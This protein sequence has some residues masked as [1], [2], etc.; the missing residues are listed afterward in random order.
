[1][2]SAELQFN[3]TQKVAGL[4]GLTAMWTGRSALSPLGCRASRFGDG[5]TGTEGRMI[6]DAEGIGSR[7]PWFDCPF[8]RIP[9]AAGMADGLSA[10]PDDSVAVHEGIAQPGVAQPEVTHDVVGIK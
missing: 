7:R 6:V 9:D 5:L 10:P 8:G 2:L 1:M 4:S 3:S